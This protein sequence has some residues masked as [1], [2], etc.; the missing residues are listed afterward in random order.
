MRRERKS[1][2]HR[3]QK[4]YDLINFIVCFVVPLAIISILYTFICLRLWKSQDMLRMKQPR[5]EIA[6][7]CAVPAANVTGG[8]A[9][10]TIATDSQQQQQMVQERQPTLHRQG[11]DSCTNYS[12]RKTQYASTSSVQSR[13]QQHRAPFQQ[14]STEPRLALQ[15][16]QADGRTQV[17]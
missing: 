13:Q 8:Q 3:M 14:L 15:E 2:Y 10:P 11:S 1:S 7:A 12:A 4:I 16:V 5:D 9:T 6:A 17:S